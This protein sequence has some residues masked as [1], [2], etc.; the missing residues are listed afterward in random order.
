MKNPASTIALIFPAVGIILMSVAVFMYFQ[1]AVFQD[2]DPLERWLGPGIAGG[3]GILFLI[4]GV[5]MYFSLR[6]LSPDE[7]KEKDQTGIN[8][9]FNPH[10]LP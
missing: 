10:N 3:I 5:V 7:K 9:N 8:D 4:I 6:S 2:L 1:E